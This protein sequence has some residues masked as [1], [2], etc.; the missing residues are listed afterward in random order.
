MTD[1]TRRKSF[2]NPSKNDV[3]ITK[4]TKR[5][6]IAKLLAFAVSTGTVFVHNFQNPVCMATFC[7]SLSRVFLS[8]VLGN[9]DIVNSY[10]IQAFRFATLYS[11][12]F[13]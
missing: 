9:C 11:N 4:I 1:N 12:P 5:K 3:E 10:S 8:S 2:T 7:R 13:G 6:A